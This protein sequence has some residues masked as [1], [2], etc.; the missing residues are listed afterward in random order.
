MAKTNKKSKGKIRNDDPVWTSA[1]NGS[2][3]WALMK[4]IWLANRKVFTQD[5]IDNAGREGE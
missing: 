1:D 5:E 2:P 4:L 3:E